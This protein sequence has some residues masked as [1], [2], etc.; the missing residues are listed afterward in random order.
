M[1]DTT[2]GFRPQ[3]RK[4]PWTTRGV[5]LLWLLATS[6]GATYLVS[7]H[8]VPLPISEQPYEDVGRAI[9]ATRTKP[10]TWLTLHV[11]YD[12][13]G[14]SQGVFDKLLDGHPDPNATE[15]IVLVGGDDETAQQARAKGYEVEI[16]EP[17]ELP[18]RYLVQAAPI[19]AVLSPDDELAYIGGY[20][21]RKRGPEPKHRQILAALQAGDHVDPLPPLGCAVSE[22]LRDAVDP[23]NLR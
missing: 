1:A 7:G 12:D 13:C 11:L 15:R 14:C 21:S 17:E 18:Q 8:W 5:L 19:Y 4:K 23:L 6:V 3:T 22:S 20:T 9:A 2:E 10:G 16:L